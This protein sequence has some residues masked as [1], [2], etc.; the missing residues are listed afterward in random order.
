MT[1]QLTHT[2]FIKVPCTGSWQILTLEGNMGLARIPPLLLA[3]S[4]TNQ[5]IILF[6]VCFY[7]KT[8]WVTCS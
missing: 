1:E 4:K 6:H 5:Y 7:V 3:F 8:Y 2:W